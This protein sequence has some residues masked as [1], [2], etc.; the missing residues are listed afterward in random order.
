MSTLRLCALAGGLA[1]C[2]V[3]SAC[4]EAD[5]VEAIRQQQA[6]GDYQGSLDPLRELLAIRP[7]DP[8]ANYRYGLAL[9]AVQRPSLA[10]FSLRKA[11]EDPDWLLPAGTQ[12]AFAALGQR[13][14]NE[15][16]EIAGLMLEHD[17]EN[18]PALLMRANA[19]AHWRNDPQRAL[20]DANRVLELAPETLEAYEP[21]ILALL[22]LERLDEARKALAEAG[23]RLGERSPS[24]ELLAWHCTTTALFAQGAGE[25]EQAR[26]TWSDCLEAHPS[27]L[28]VVS[29]AVGFYDEQGEHDRAQEVLRAALAYTP[30]S[31]TLRVSIAERLRVQ[32]KAAEAEAVL[33]EATRAEHPQLAA[34]GW[35]DLGTLRQ[36]L[37]EHGA[38]ADAMGRAFELAQQAGAPTP[39]LA[40]GYADALVL[41]GQHDRALAVAEDLSVPA[42]RH[43]V[44][45]RVAQERRRPAQALEEFDLALRLW[46]DNPWARYQAAR[47]AEELGDFERAIDE[48]RYAIRISAGATDARTRAATLLAAE[49]KSILALQLLRVAP[50]QAPLELEGQLLWT[51]LSGLLGDLGGV[52]ASFER[53]EKSYPGSIGQAAQAAAEGIAQRSGPAVALQMLSTAP[54]I[55]FDDPRHAAALRA[56][57]RLAHEAGDIAATQAALESALATHPGSAVF[58]EIR[59]LDLELSGAP[60]EAVRAAYARALELGPRNPGALAGMGRLASGEDPELA[61]G[62]FDRAAAADPSDAEPKLMAARALVALGKPDVAAE[63]LDTLLREHPTEA[64]AAADCARLDLERGGARSRTLERARRAVRFGGGVEALDLLSR[65][66]AQRG[67]PEDAARASERARA[68]RETRDPEA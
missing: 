27:N 44:R 47:A 3:S 16:V 26:E 57:V 1:A 21:R 28:D 19:Y 67:E 54:G 12:L 20:D 30:E 66:H 34:A 2:L 58:Y 65:V 18:V 39:E 42:H 10:T 36:A 32:G 60:P 29:N 6:A 35:M 62:F 31:R 33:R 51:R 15:A 40:F 63:R 4:G 43:M 50:G 46:P 11:M 5:P 23:R 24:P 41:A 17:P 49:R 8:E 56:R 7:D 37:G 64:R 9:V 14:F 61:L 59:G 52:V 53:M 68:L 38:A 55:D 25:L 48:Y 45:A 13:D 22:S